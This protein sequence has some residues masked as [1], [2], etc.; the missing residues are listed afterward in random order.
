MAEYSYG[1]PNAPPPAPDPR[2]AIQEVLRA[3]RRN[4]VRVVFAV[5]VA[6]MIGYALT[7]IWPDKYMSETK[8]VLRESR[9]VSATMADDLRDIPLPRKLATLEGELQSRKRIAAVMG[10]LQW[11]EWLET[12][13]SE[14]QRRELVLKIK[15]NLGV[16]METDNV[17]GTHITLQF[18]WLRPHKAAQ[19]VN[20]LRDHWITLTLDNH[21][22]QIEDHKERLEAV[23]AERQDTYQAALRARQKFE[24]EHDVPS[25]LTL[26]VNN[27]IKGELMV[28]IPEAK[29]Q[30]DSAISRV[31]RLEGELSS[32]EPE[33]ELPVP[34]KSPEHAQALAALAQARAEFSAKQRDYTPRNPVYIKAESAVKEAEAK[35]EALGID[36]NTPLNLTK[37]QTNPAYFDKVQEWELAREEEVKWRA[38]VSRLE[39]E[40]DAV[41]ARLDKLPLVNSRMQELDDAV[42]QASKLL[43]DANLEAQPIR[44]QVAQLRRQVQTNADA[45]EF[46]TGPFEVLE[47]GVEPETPVLPIGALIMAFAL[48]AGLVLGVAGPI[49]GEFT[50]SSFG[51]VKEVSRNLGVPV[52]GAVDLILTTRDTRARLVQR[53]LTMT[54]MALV[55]LAM[56]TALYIYTNLPEVLPASL[57]NFVRDLRLA[58]T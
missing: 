57:H 38:Q 52:L 10:E 36:E 15:R 54:T 35:L 5:L 53:A 43:E 1:D 17:G 3:I 19:F 26:E 13:S 12:G 46:S 25:L 44:D 16:Q 14:A 33:I 22:R 11:V 55:L 28:K 40:L 23:V 56:G 24:Q 50:R 48:V 20:H 45:G 34:P 9:I 41:Q 29:A 27:T 18:Q 49:L 2:E 51:S 21:R 4:T 42:G 39:E 37:L 31:E 47:T 30:L 6:L 58:L 32:I 8:F 7:L